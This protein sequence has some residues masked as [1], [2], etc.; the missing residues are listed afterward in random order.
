MQL[1]S[2]RKWAQLL[3]TSVARLREIPVEI[4]HDVDSHYRF[5]SERKPGSDKVRHYM[6]PKHELKGIHK[7]I[8]SN[9]LTV[10]P[11][12]AA[13]HGGIRGKSRRS[14]ASK[15]LGQRW[16]VTMDVKSF[17][18][19]VRHY[20]VHDMFSRELGCGREVAWLLTRL[21]TLNAQLPQGAPTS[22]AV[23][24]LVLTL[25][26]DEHIAVL[27]QQNGTVNTRFVDDIALSGNDPQSLINPTVRAL[28]RKRLP[29]W[30]K[31]AKYQSRPKFKV[32]PNSQRQE[33]T[34]LVVNATSGPSVPKHYRDGV[35]TAI[36]QLRD[37]ADVEE[38]RLT[39]RS[40][41][42]RIAYVRTCNPGPAAKLTALLDRRCGVGVYG[43]QS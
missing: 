11:L 38:R 41:R 1:L 7:K 36:F 33:V 31:S 15:H 21:T 8:K 40:I 2:V 23:G 19:N 34:G 22:T 4:D 6:V 28:S 25:A 43:S 24:N 5:H 35:R 16:L 14:N 3:N 17:F 20:I 27:A 30:R 26:V 13:V 32:T 42:G 18:P 9:V 29:I 10:F 12:S 37:I 39:E